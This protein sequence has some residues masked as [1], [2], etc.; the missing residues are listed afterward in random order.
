MLVIQKLTYQTSILLLGHPAIECIQNIII[1][2]DA[3]VFIYIVPT[4]EYVCISS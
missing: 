3:P 1:V 2:S 4:S